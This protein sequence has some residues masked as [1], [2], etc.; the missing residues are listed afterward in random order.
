ME[1]FYN[2]SANAFTV[3]RYSPEDFLVCF[4]NRG[5]LEEVVQAPVPLGTPFYLVWKR[6][7]R[8]SMA[9]AGAMRYK[10]LLGLNGMPVHTWSTDTAERILGS[11][12]A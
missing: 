5:D 4:N 3:S 10:V 12:C 2:I 7:R 8:Q 6:W 11:S 1:S 9:S